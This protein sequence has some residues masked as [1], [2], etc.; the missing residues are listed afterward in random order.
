MI[1]KLSWILAFL[2]LIVV[3]VLV[4]TFN[5]NL[6][7]RNVSDALKAAQQNTV[8]VQELGN[9]KDEY[10]IIELNEEQHFENSIYISFSELTQNE[11]REKLESLNGAILLYSKDI[12]TSAK[13]WVILNQLGFHSVFILSD[14][15]NPEALNYKFR[16]DTTIRPE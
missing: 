14:E 10:T 3:M 2:L 9:M 16:P 8:S 7:K 5:P 15:A 11:N 13:A 6:F 1:K 4:R 12:S